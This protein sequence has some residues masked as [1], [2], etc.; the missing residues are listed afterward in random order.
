MKRHELVVIGGGPAG[1]AAAATAAQTGVNCLLMD[2]QATKATAALLAMTQS[3]PNDQ[4]VWYLLAEAYGL[5]KD[6]VGVHQARA[7][8]FIRVGNFEQAIKQLD[9]ASPMVRDNFQQTARI[10]QRIEEIFG[11]IAETKKS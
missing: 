8:Y 4:D 7:E 6:I 11:M 3:R 1:L 2:E 5:D 9:F 10:R